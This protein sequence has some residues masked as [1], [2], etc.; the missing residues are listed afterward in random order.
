MNKKIVLPSLFFLVGMTPKASNA[1]GD[2]AR[3]LDKNQY[4]M[5]A[6]FE[7]DSNLIR[8]PY[9]PQVFSREYVNT[10]MIDSFP[11]NN[12]DKISEE[13][14]YKVPNSLEYNI[15]SYNKCVRYTLP[16]GSGFVRMSGSRTWR[17]MNPGAIRPGSFSK[18]YGACGAAGGFA[19]FP[20]EEHGMKALKGLLL[21]DKYRQLT[22]ASAIYK[23]APPSDHNN[24]KSY[25]RKLSNMTGLSLSKRLNTLT[26]AELDRVANAIKTIEGWKVGTEK[27]FENSK[28]ITAANVFM[29]YQN[30]MQ[31]QYNA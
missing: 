31:R 15:L 4:S 11:A 16:D 29:N 8:I 19:V 14:V 22:I 23:W 9:D 27:T 7:V 21:S 26:P 3:T 12:E 28:E 6:K 25:Q 30:M 2:D 1:A 18:Q 10:Y 20:T 13:A 24:T 17:N 5:S